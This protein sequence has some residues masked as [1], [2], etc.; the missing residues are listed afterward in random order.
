MGNEK[1]WRKE[2]PEKFRETKQKWRN[3]HK[4]EQRQKERERIIKFRQRHPDYYKNKLPEAREK[5]RIKAITNHKLKKKSNCERCGSTENLEFH[6]KKYTAKPEDIMTLC[7]TCHG[8][9]H[10][11]GNATGLIDLRKQ[12]ARMTG[13]N[14]TINTVL[15]LINERI[16]ASE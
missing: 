1:K 14:A 5:A 12:V 2:N 8:L 6:H 3:N 7:R 16:K 13:D 9:L 15:E 4:E 10:R 11:K